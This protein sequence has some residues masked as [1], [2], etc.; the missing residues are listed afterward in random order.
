MEQVKRK[1]KVNMEHPV[2]ACPFCGSGNVV[3]V[4]S[5]I[6]EGPNG[7]KLDTTQLGCKD[8]GQECMIG[9]LINKEEVYKNIPIS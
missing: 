6:H 8:C 7:S 2:T 9:R 3:E 1:G 4:D 5:Y